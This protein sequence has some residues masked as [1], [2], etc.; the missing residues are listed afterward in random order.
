MIERRHLHVKNGTTII[1]RSFANPLL[2]QVRQDI[3]LISYEIL[4]TESPY[5]LRSLIKLKIDTC[6]LFDVEN[7]TTIIVK[8]FANSSLGPSQTGHIPNFLR[9]TYD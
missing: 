6:W 7:D 9:N 8:S 3:Y 2:V 5:R 1:V 4:M